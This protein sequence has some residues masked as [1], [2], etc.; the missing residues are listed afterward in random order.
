MFTQT[1]A[2]YDLIYQARGK[3]Y[4][5]EAEAVAGLIRE[6][7]PAAR[8]LLDVGCGT[9]AHIAEFER[10]GFACHGIDADFKMVSL[11]RSRVPEAPIEPGDMTTFA[12][13]ERFD[14]IVSLFG[15]AS[16]ARVPARL[17]SAIAR[18]ARHLQPAGLLVIEPFVSYADYRPGVVN[19][20]FVD[21]PDI[22]IA[23]MSVSKQMGRIGILDFHYLVATLT[24]VERYF[25]RHEIGLFDEGTYREAF[26]KA[27]LTFEVTDVPQSVFTRALYAGRR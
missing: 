23:R 20:I 3:D 14:A 21:Q 1:T 10:L 16:Y 18:M 19:A 6:R 8:T 9:G 17:E 25:E 7:L 26:V 5:R 2:F 27:G 13:N 11:A 12:L 24:G 4:A 22:K 15:T